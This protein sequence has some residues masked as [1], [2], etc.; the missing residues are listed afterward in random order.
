MPTIGNGMQ[1]MTAPMGVPCG[2]GY[3]QE[4]GVPAE[5]ATTDILDAGDDRIGHNRLSSND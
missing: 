2:V 3:A 1:A 4:F 5:H